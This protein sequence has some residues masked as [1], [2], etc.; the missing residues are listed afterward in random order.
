[1]GDVLYGAGALVLLMT[2]IE[3]LI[4]TIRVEAG[5]MRRVSQSPER[6]GGASRIKQ[7]FASRLALNLI[8][9]LLALILGSAALWVAFFDISDPWRA[10]VP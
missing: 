10:A 6:H 3:A 9:P 1:M 4:R 7:V 8:E 2:G 5:E